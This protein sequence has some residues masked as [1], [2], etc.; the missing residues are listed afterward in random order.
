MNKITLEDL[1]LNSIDPALFLNYIRSVP[2]GDFSNQRK[3]LNKKLLKKET[4]IL[5]TL[6]KSHFN[7]KISEARYIVIY[8]LK[9]NFGYTYQEL[10]EAFSLKYPTGRYGSETVAG[11]IKYDNEYANIYECF[12]KEAD[13]IMESIH[14]KNI[15]KVKFNLIE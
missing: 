5:F 1:Y 15:S 9:A 12:K 13:E 10:G 14:Q 4:D 2:L 11:Y 8:Y 7:C 6:V 3:V